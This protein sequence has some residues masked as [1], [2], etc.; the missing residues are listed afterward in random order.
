MHVVH[1]FDH[2]SINDD[3]VACD[4]ANIPLDDETLD[5]AVFSL[6]LM[7]ANFTDYLREAHRTLKIDGQLHVFESTSRF[8]DRDAFIRDLKQLGFDQFA[9]E[10][11]W[12]FTYIKALKARR[13]PNENVELRF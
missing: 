5:L 2:V 10:D 11:R 13:R 6:S 7:G 3:V 1:S 12:K 8:S 9:V 4:M